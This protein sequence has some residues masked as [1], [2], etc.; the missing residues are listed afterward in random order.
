MPAENLIP[1]PAHGPSRGRTPGEPLP[2]LAWLR[3]AAVGLAAL[4][5]AACTWLPAKGGATAAAKPEPPPAPVLPPA[6]PPA[7][8]IAPADLAGPA[9]RAARRLLAYNEQLLQMDAAGIAA[10]IARLD[11]QVLPSSPMTTPDLT[12][13]LALA[14]VQQHNP[15]DLARAADLLDPIVQAT[16]PEAQPW[17]PIA[18]LLAAR[19]ADQRRLEDQLERQAARSRDT[20][21]T[22]QQ[23]TEKLEALKAIERSM[24]ARPAAP[25]KLVP[26]SGTPTGDAPPAAVKLP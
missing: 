5:V 14:L 6:P 21:H 2:W 24:T 1:E 16:A 3:P 22:I 12:L 18:R 9:D 26:P 11:A 7:P 13:A 10:D 17:Q 20:Q 19:I 23:L 15:G 25:P 4:G 8:V